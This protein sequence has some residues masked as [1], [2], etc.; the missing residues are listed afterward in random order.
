MT[1]Q[2]VLAGVLMGLAVAGWPGRPPAPQWVTPPGNGFPAAAPGGSRQGRSPGG[3]PLTSEDVASSMVLL[4]LALQSGC[5]VVEA[6]EHVAG[7]SPGRPG[8]D[9][10]TVAAA[11][12]WGIAERGAWV[13]VDPAWRSAVSRCGWRPEP[14]WARPGCSSRGRAT[15]G[16]ASWPAWRLTQRE[17]ASA[18]SC[19]WG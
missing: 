18:W 10:S 11:L 12:R 15:C 9:L 4:A 8:Q 17:S 6:I 3:G 1:G 19:P 16:R 14:A 7:Q 5:G 2:L 13:A